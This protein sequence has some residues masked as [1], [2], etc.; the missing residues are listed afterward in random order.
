MKIKTKTYFIVMPIVIVLILL[1][2]SFGLWYFY[3]SKKCIGDI[4][5]VPAR[6]P[7]SLGGVLGK[8]GQKTDSGDYYLFN[9]KKF[10][11]LNDAKS[12]CIWL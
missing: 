5:Y 8:F 3:K 7:E 10:K 11:T 9:S 6:E 2:A 1:G 12:Y 4:N